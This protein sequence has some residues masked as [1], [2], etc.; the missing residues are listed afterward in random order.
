MSTTSEGDKK[1]W[2]DVS[3]QTSA[4]ITENYLLPYS[5]IQ[6]CTGRHKGLQGP[7][8]MLEKDGILSKDE[9]AAIYFR[10]CGY[11]R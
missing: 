7:C 4:S 6:E 11:P 1:L 10:P 3:A 2:G 5:M 8:R 9:S